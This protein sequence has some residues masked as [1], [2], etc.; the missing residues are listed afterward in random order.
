[1]VTQSQNL[2]RQKSIPEIYAEGLRYFMGEGTLNETLERLS[3]DLDERG[4][5]YMVIGAEEPVRKSE[6][7]QER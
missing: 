1:M 7:N 2:D 3:R 6:L 5:D 4:I